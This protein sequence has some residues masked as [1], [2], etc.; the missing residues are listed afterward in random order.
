MTD[1]Q[2]LPA[3]TPEG[4]KAFAGAKRLDPI[5]PTFSGKIITGLLI[6]IRALHAVLLEARQ[7]LGE[8]VAWSEDDD[9]DVD[10]LIEPSR[11][12]LERLRATKGET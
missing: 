11:K 7:I 12:L 3:L 8:L 1:T 2:N 6:E 9:L 5:V 4:E 10:A